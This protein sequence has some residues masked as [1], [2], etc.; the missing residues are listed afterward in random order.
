[1]FYGYG[2]HAAIESDKSKFF[3]FANSVNLRGASGEITIF[4]NS[5]K[6]GTRDVPA[7]YY[8]LHQNAIYHFNKQN[9][10]VESIVRTK[11]GANVYLKKSNEIQKRTIP[12]V[13]ISLTQISE[14][15]PLKKK[16]IPN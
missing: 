7:G 11:N 5:K 10:E 4:Y 8:Q 9:Y 13:K 6:I 14:K 16:S 1:L 15:N 12:I 3:D 2:K